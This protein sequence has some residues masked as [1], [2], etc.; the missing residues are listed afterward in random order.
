MGQVLNA[1]Y[2]ILG[3]HTITI[4]A[5]GTL[6]LTIMCRTTQQRLRIKIHIPPA[7]LWMLAFLNLSVVTR[8][9]MEIVDIAPWALISAA[10]YSIGFI[11]FFIWI[12]RQFSLN[13]PK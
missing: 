4:A 3:I 1:P 2:S 9:L 6:I 13:S 7:L 11:L 12:M 5:L 8:L 10:S